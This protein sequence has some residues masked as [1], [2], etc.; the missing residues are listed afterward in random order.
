LWFG[1]QSEFGFAVP[2][3]MTSGG[4]L[5]VIVCVALAVWLAASIAGGAVT[6]RC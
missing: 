4:A 1:G 2:P 3:V 6:R 5:T